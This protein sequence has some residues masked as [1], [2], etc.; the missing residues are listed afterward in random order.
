MRCCCMR[1][2]SERRSPVCRPPESATHACSLLLRLLIVLTR[3]DQPR[4]DSLASSI[5]P[6]LRGSHWGT[7]RG[8]DRRS[9]S[10]VFL[11]QYLASIQQFRWYFPAVVGQLLHDGFVQPEIHRGGPVQRA[12][13][14]Q[15]RREFLAGGQAAVQAHEFE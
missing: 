3:N 10:A 9:P 1:E 15:I 14:P 13:V 2:P 7:L 12:C 6:R 11:G 4:E 5:A 8:R